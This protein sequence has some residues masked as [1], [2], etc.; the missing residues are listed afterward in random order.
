MGHVQTTRIEQERHHAGHRPVSRKQAQACLPRGTMVAGYELLKCIG[1]G[2]QAAV[3]DTRSFHRGGFH[4]RVAMKVSHVHPQ[5]SKNAPGSLLHEAQQ[6]RSLTHSGV[7]GVF[8]SG[9]E[10]G[11]EYIAMER[12]E[13]V[14]L[15]RL[16]RRGGALPLGACVDIGIKLCDALAYLHGQL[17]ARPTHPLLHLD[18]K[19]GN[20]MVTSTGEVKLI[21]FGVSRSLDKTDDMRPAGYGT[22]AYMA[23]EQILRG[24]LSPATDVFSV[25]A[26]LFE[27]ATGRRIFEGKDVNKLL[28]ERVREE[29]VTGDSEERSTGCRA[30]DRTITRAI[31]RNP[32][33]RTRKAQF[34]GRSLRM[35]KRR[36]GYDRRLNDYLSCPQV[37]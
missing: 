17:S 22:P 25:G 7:V 28:V 6:L 11:L 31:R 16:L 12:I 34:L 3:Y 9:R 10:N 4:R 27:M 13:G 23:P 2:G 35:L 15:K 19:P 37:C 32:Q 8:G 33:A 36:V 24:T 5:G 30:L 26:L 29:T 18:L 14:S 20:V 21:D 1:I